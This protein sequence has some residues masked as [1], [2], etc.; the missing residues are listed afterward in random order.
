M[1]TTTDLIKRFLTDDWQSTSQIARQVKDAGDA[2]IM[3]AKVHRILS[4][5]ARYGLVEKMVVPG[6]PG[7]KTTYWR[8]VQ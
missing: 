5:D 2:T 3:S 8:R 4:S 6:G 1:S 7:G